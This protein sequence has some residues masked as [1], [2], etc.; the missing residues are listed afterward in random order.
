MDHRQIPHQVHHQAHH[1]LSSQRQQ[2][3]VSGSLTEKLNLSD[4][5]VTILAA[6]TDRLGDMLL[7]LTALQMLKEEYPL[8][9]LIFMVRAPYQTLLKDLTV[10]G[11]KVIDELLVY[12]PDGEH[13]GFKGWWKLVSYFRAQKVRISILF[14]SDFKIGTALIFGHV[15]YRVGSWSRWYSYLIFNLGLRQRRSLV[16]MH[17]AEYNHQLVAKI[18]EKTNETAIGRKF[19]PQLSL[20]SI[21]RTLA[22][23]W[24]ALQ[25]LKPKTYLWIH[26]GMGG[27]ALNWPDEHYVELIRELLETNQTSDDPVSI[28]LSFGP[29]DQHKVNFYREQLKEYSSIRWFGVRGSGENSALAVMAALMEQSLLVIAPSTGPLHLAA[30]TGVPT[31]SVYPPVRVQSAIR[32]GVYGPDHQIAK[33][34]VP[35]VYCGQDF[36]CIGK[37]CSFYPCMERVLPQTLAQSVFKIIERQKMG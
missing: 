8:S 26:P 10:G 30:A 1:H 17:E 15:R 36:K 3:R 14:I 9:R 19:F 22:Q 2:R 11:V 12:D 16:H 4:R 21:D 7:T 33:I 18:A 13:R 27:S 25:N 6:R 23:E 34:F 20:S 31:M 5:Q 37:K 28:V 29:Q 35:E 32:W 24:L